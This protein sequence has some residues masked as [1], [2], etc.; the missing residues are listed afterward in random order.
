MIRA[1]DRTALQPMNVHRRTRVGLTGWSLHLTDEEVEQVPFLPLIDDRLSRLV[2]PAD[3]LDGRRGI[4]RH[5]VD[6]APDLD[7]REQLIQLREDRGTLDANLEHLVVGECG[8]TPD[9]QRGD[10][11]REAVM[12][13]LSRPQ[14][15]AV[16]LEVRRLQAREP[17]AVVGG[18]GQRPR[19][20]QYGG[21]DLNQ[22]SSNGRADW[23]EVFPALQESDRGIPRVRGGERFRGDLRDRPCERRMDAGDAHDHLSEFEE[24]CPYESLRVVEKVV[25]KLAVFNLHG[26]RSSRTRTSA[27]RSSA[28]PSDRTLSSDSSR[29]VTAPREGTSSSSTRTGPPPST[30][31]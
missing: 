28:S 2:R 25:R 1:I 18:V 14:R 29:S 31:R 24:A 12:R 23:P 6:H 19:L 10:L 15:P 4:V 9:A 17:S 11:F 13:I 26:V 16:L 7:P 20:R 30:Y 5:E 21:V 8:E 3:H 22:D 27:R